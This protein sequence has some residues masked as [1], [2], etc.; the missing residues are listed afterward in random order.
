[1]SR[2]GSSFSDDPRGSVGHDEAP[3]GHADRASI[4]LNVPYAAQTG[5]VST[6]TSRRPLTATTPGARGALMN[7]ALT[8]VAGEGDMRTSSVSA[9]S[10]VSTPSSR[11]WSWSPPSG[12][13]VSRGPVAK[14]RRPGPQSHGASARGSAAASCRYCGT[15]RLGAG[16]SVR[17]LT[18]FANVRQNAVMDHVDRVVAVQRPVHAGSHFQAIPGGPL[19]ARPIARQAREPELAA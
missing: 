7:R 17:R 18:Q 16:P 2:S 4:L 13:G 15:N 1:M 19:Q 5:N 11:L 14:P 9:A 6:T 8:T 10:R 12:A 3:S